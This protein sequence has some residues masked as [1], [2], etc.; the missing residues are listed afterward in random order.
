MYT[1]II[2]IQLTFNELGVRVV[3]AKM[4]YI[5]LSSIKYYAY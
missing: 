5:A 2:Y 4:F 3:S 1:K